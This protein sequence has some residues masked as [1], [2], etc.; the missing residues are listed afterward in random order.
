MQQNHR[1]QAWEDGIFQYLEFKIEVFNILFDTRDPLKILRVKAIRKIWFQENEIGRYSQEGQDK[2][3][4]DAVK[5]QLL[6][7]SGHEEIR[8]KQTA[9]LVKTDVKKTNIH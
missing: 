1:R 3:R 7:Q 2:D 6:Y 8:L 9:D 4:L 5:S